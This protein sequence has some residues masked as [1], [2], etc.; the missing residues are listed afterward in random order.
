[1]PIDRRTFL[2][3]SSSMLFSGAALL[4]AES[5]GR[6]PLLVNGK[7]AASFYFGQEWDKPFLYPIRTV[8]GKAISRG[9]PLEKIAGEQTDHVWH[10]GLWYGHGIISGQDFWRELGREKTSRLVAK[11]APV[12]K[13]RKD[14]PAVTAD[15]SMVTP[16]GKALGSIRQEWRITDRERLRLIDA[17]ITIDAD[18]GEPLVFGDADDGGFAFRL[19]DA[20][21]Q[22]RGAKLRNSSGLETTEQIWG[23]PAHW[24]DYSAVIDGVP[25]G[26]AIL[27][28]PANLRYPTA[29]H[30]RGYSLCAANPFATRSFSKGKGPDGGY[31]LPAGKQLRLR[32]RVVI[33]EGPCE[34]PVLEKL[35]AEWAKR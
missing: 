26:V 2:L 23:K 9:Y 25:T 10:R 3:S 17:T 30:A 31:T 27:D 12:V 6:V 14:S 19:N 18:Q 5:A 16:A 8:S 33:H 7:E 22:D 1:M 29:W 34:P 4:A 24:V 35:H 11:H 13:T 20:F 28:H 32:Y 15:F 21:R